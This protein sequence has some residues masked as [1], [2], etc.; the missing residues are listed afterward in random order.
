MV[1]RKH[2]DI[3]PL[4]EGIINSEIEEHIQDDLLAWHEDTITNNILRKFRKQLR[5]LTIK[6]GQRNL[7]YTNA[8]FYKNTGNTETR[9]GDIAIILQ[10]SYDDDNIIEG[11]G[12]IEAKKMNKDSK[13]FTSVRADQLER[14]LTNASHSYLMLYDYEQINQDKN[15]KDYLISKRSNN[16]FPKTFYASLIP[17]KLALEFAQFNRKIYRF[18]TPFSYQLIY[19]YIYGLDLDFSSD[20]INVAKGNQTEA[21]FPPKYLVT[22][23]VKHSKIEGEFQSQDIEINSEYFEEITESSS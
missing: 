7:I 18:T 23:Q 2:S 13:R 11:V 20:L 6:Y 10:I 9:I 22:I 16:V 4:V 8:N 21:L 12:I 14:I 1:E 17:I 19:R 5:N 15:Y 3:I